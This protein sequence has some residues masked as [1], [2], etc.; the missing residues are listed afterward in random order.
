LLDSYQ[1]ERKP[2]VRFI[3]EKAIELGRFRRCVTRLRRASGTS[4]FSLNGARTKDPRSCVYPGLRGGLVAGSGEFF[5][6]GHVRS[7]GREGLFDD[8]VGPG[9]CILACEP[10][11]LEAL[12]FSH[13]KAWKA[14]GGRIATVA[15]PNTA[16]ALEDVD[17]LY[18]AWFATHSC[19]VAVVRPDW[20]LYGT[21]RDGRELTTL[22]DRLAQSLR[23]Q[24]VHA[25]S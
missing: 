13:R 19:S 8:I 10:D 11:V 2:H 16:G 14:I 24:P 9:W 12:T 7:N 6:Q 18:H 1:P 5:P 4:G 15:V 21:A 17:G 20:Y 3:T 23:R 25:S 22:L